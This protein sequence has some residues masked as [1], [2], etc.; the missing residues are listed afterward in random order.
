MPSAS[1]HLYTHEYYPKQGGIATYCHEFAN[2]ASTQLN[3][4][5]TVYAPKRAQLSDSDS[6][7]YRLKIGKNTGTHNLPSLLHTRNRLR[8]DFSSHANAIHL[9]AEPGPILAFGMLASSQIS[10]QVHLTLHGS[11]IQRWARNPF[12]KPLAARAMQHARRII[13]VSHPIAELAKKHY[14]TL[15]HKIHAV[16]NALPEAHRPN[17]PPQERSAS[18]DSLKLLCVGRIH[19]RKGFDQIITAIGSLPNTSKQAIHTTIAGSSKDGRYLQRLERLAQQLGVTV[20]FKLNQSHHELSQCYQCADLFALTSVPYRNSVEGFGLVYLEAGA[21]GLPCIAY[22]IGGVKDAV[23]H[24]K[25]GHLLPV[26]DTTALAQSI[27]FFLNN[28]AE[29]LKLGSNNFRHSTERT[30]A[31]VAR[32]TLG[33]SK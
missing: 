20:E 18:P 31:D 27:Q 1:L 21:H 2:A 7:T 17:H 29:R 12:F 32:E 9:L 11:E 10:E 25:T 16:C 33:F 14:P 30:W 6:D 24:N 4:Q 3:Q 15:A 26:G 28:P 8:T 13:C 5:V 23:L 22:D 19:P